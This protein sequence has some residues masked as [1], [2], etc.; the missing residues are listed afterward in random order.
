VVQVRG[1]ER[2]D[3]SFGSLRTEKVPYLPNF[4]QAIDALLQIY[5]SMDCHRHRSVKP[6]AQIATERFLKVG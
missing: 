5:G 1:E 2:K 3:K 4:V 6:G